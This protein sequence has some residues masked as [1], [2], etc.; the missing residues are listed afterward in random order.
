MVLIDSVTGEERSNL[1]STLREPARVVKFSP[2]GSSR[3][4][5]VFSEVRSRIPMMAAWR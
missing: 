5:M 3:D 4:L 1:N 2:E